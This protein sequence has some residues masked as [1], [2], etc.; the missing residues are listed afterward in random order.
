[1]LNC[2]FWLSRNI[3]TNGLGL[4]EGVEFEI[5]MFKLAPKP[6]SIPNAEFST[7]ATLLANPCVC[8]EWTS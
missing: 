3:A 4:A 7:N 2:Q 1:M 6:N 8:P 5:R